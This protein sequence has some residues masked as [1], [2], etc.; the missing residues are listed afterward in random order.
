MSRLPSIEVGL[1]DLPPQ[2]DR[3]RSRLSSTA[4]HHRV[5][6]HAIDVLDSATELPSGYDFIWLSQFLDCFSEIQIVEILGRVRATMGPEA[7][8]WILELFWDRQRFE[9][10]AISLQLTSLYFACVANGK[11]QMYDSAVFIGLVK[12]AGFRICAVT[13]SVGEFHTLLECRP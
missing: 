11:S 7:R 9:A 6:F 12:R 5:R 10:A 2:L 4:H 3:A 8:L 13:D 1:A